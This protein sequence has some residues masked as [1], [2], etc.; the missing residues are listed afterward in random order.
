MQYPPPDRTLFDG[1]HQLRP[2]QYLLADGGLVVTRSYWDMEYPPAGAPGGDGD[3][4][5][6]AGELL[7]RL[8]EAVRLRLRADVPVCCHLSGGLDSA[9]VSALAARH[10]PRPVCF[11]VSFDDVRY[12]ELDAAREIAAHI[13]AEHVP[14]AAS[15]AVLAGHL[16]DAVYYSE[17]LAI[18]GH[19][20]AKFL[21]SRA[22]HRAG[23]KA[24]LSG[25]GADEILG[26]YAHLK[27]D[28]FLDPASGHADPTGS[29]SALV[30]DNHLMAGIHLAEGE[31]LDLG[32]VRHALG[33]VP[34]FLGAKG[35]LGRRMRDLLH[36][37]FLARFAGRD[38]FADF[39]NQCDLP[40][41]LAGRSR[42]DQSS[43][44]WTKS[45]LATYILRTLGDGTEMA[46]SVEGRLPFL[47]PQVFAFS[48]GL[49]VGLKIRRGVEKYVLRES[50]RPLLP[51]S[52]YRRPKHPFTAPPSI[53]SPGDPF[54][55]YLHD[56]LRGDAIA[57]LPFFEASAVRRL[58]ER[59]PSLPERERTATDPVLMLVLTAHL[60]QK[61]FRM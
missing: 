8:D 53:R 35:T 23:Y 41:Q 15:Q 50:A 40:G 7:D 10:A 39:L 11:T 28:W 19:L 22:I 61:R 9:V 47:D 52:V 32:A 29:V 26:G 46:H 43:Y 17:G 51:Q 56:E 5:A 54:D 45:S 55:E 25:E 44:L 31:S 34:S 20:P 27:R 30:A 1:V 24:V 48:K 42:V 37:D 57:A 14:V 58:L 6:A 60:L 36:P 2:G 3:T 4:R 12:D 13:G 38:P 59:L 33:F 18:N 16:S 21:L 49:P